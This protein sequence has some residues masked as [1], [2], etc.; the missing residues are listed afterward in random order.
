ML[1]VIIP[2]ITNFFKIHPAISVIGRTLNAVSFAVFTPM[3]NTLVI[4]GIEIPINYTGVNEAPF[5]ILKILYMFKI[6]QVNGILV[7][8]Y[9]FIDLRS[10]LTILGIT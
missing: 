9:K 5:I 8:R 4:R 10:D 2:V 6:V 7:F 3:R 1:F